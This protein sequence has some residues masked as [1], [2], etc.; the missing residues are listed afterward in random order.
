MQ[1]TF[2][3]M[4]GGRG[5]ECGTIFIELFSQPKFGLFRVWRMG[6]QP[7]DTPV[8]NKIWLYFTMQIFFLPK[9]TF[10]M[11]FTN[12]N[13]VDIINPPPSNIRVKNTQ[14][15][16]RLTKCALTCESLSNSTYIKY[17]S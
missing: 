9:F 13:R 10:S 6:D 12:E 15:K 14:S 17:G 2:A 11:V 8:N 3:L 1:L 5:V 16:V 7:L 4:G